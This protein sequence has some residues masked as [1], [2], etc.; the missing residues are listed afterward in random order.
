M[1]DRCGAGRWRTTATR[2]GVVR[3]QCEARDGCFVGIGL[4]IER[5]IV[6]LQLDIIEV[7][8]RCRRGI[9]QVEHG[10][11]VDQRG[12]AATGGALHA[13]QRGAVRGGDARGAAWSQPAAVA[14]GHHAGA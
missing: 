13:H 4:S 8:N 3:Q 1:R 5:R 11:R 2:R 9:E 14:G 10:F 7:A 12:G 6:E